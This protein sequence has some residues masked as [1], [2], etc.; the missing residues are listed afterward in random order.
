MTVR[1]AVVS[2]IDASHSLPDSREL[3]L[4]RRTAERWA[5]RRR[6]RLQERLTA[7]RARTEISGFDLD[8]MAPCRRQDS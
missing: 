4:A 8:W 6:R 5:E 2:L 3:I 7:R 1:E